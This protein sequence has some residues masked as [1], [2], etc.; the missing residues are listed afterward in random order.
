MRCVTWRCVALRCGIR[1]E[2]TLSRRWGRPIM[3]S[4][5]Y[6]LL[7][8]YSF[9]SFPLD[10]CSILR[11]MFCSMAMTGQFRLGL[12]T[13]THTSSSRPTIYENLMLKSVSNWT[14]LKFSSLKMEKKF[15]CIQMEDVYLYAWQLQW[16][17]RKRNE[18]W[19]ISVNYKYSAVA[20][21]SDRLATIDMGRKLSCA[22]FGGSW[23]PI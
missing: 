19:T 2:R 5:P 3:W 8:M 14:E 21:M 6:N 20:E 15:R 18:K 4:V 9:I 16:N 17:D 11:S 7:A 23:V 12:N 1:C 13:H 22:P 10:C